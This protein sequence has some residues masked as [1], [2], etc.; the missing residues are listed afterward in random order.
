[1]S[2][3]DPTPELE[4]IIAKAEAGELPRKALTFA[5]DAQVRVAS[6]LETI[7]S[8]S[9]NGLDPTTAQEDA[10]ENIYR[11]ACKWLHRKP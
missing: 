6:I 4:E 3:D 8:M 5:T 2:Y 11:G 9:D 10:L 1:M 7:E